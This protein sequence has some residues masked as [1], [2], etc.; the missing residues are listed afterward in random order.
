M[1]FLK[2]IVL[3]LMV[4]MVPVVG[5]AYIG[6][7]GQSNATDNSGSFKTR[8]LADIKIINVTGSTA[9][10]GSAMCASTVED[11]GYRASECSVEGGRAL[12][13]LTES[14]DDL[15]RCSCR[16]HGYISGVNWVDSGTGTEDATA[17]QCLYVSGD[18][19]GAVQGIAGD[20]S[21]ASGTE[22]NCLGVFLDSDTADDASV[23]AY[24]NIR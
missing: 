11:D 9:S 5:N 16:Q 23:E 13:F 21:V 2:L 6:P 3:T 10:S 22:R 20:S 4:A 24:I 15:A 12:C 1:N 19:N 14:C 18:D 8:E 7:D 17:G